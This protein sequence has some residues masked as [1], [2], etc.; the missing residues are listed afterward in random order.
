MVSL[1]KNTAEE[2]NGKAPY[3]FFQETGIQQKRMNAVNLPVGRTLKEKT[4][5]ADFKNDN[6]VVDSDEVNC[7]T[8]TNL[9]IENHRKEV[10]TLQFCY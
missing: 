5:R 1:K 2:G 9:K 3:L 7:I 10:K 4:V 6:F 8:Y